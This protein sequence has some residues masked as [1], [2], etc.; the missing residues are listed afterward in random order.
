MPGGGTIKIDAMIGKDGKE[1]NSRE[2]KAKIIIADD[3]SGMTRNDLKRLFEPF[4]TTKP[5]GTGLG[6][7]TVY[8]IIETHGGTISVE[9]AVDAGTTF[10]IFLPVT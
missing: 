6:L 7:A 3:G 9:S 4:F 1:A 2:D 5:G 10:T 8:R